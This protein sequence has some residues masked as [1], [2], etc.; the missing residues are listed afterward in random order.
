MDFHHLLT[1]EFVGT[2]VPA[3]FL[4][5]S[6][7]YSD[8]VAVRWRDGSG[9]QSLAWRQVQERI[10]NLSIQLKK[11]GVVAGDRVAVMAANSPHWVWLDMAV[12]CLGAHTVPIYPTTAVAKLPKLFKAVDC[13]AIALGDLSVRRDGDHEVAARRQVAG[14]KPL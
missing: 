4:E 11:L 7:R 3:L 6:S 10:F 2:T 9:E 14:D 1:Q 5:A 13:K 12:S 8:R